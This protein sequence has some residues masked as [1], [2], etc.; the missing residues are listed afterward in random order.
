[1]GVW[2]SL[3]NVEIARRFAEEEPAST[4]WP[5]FGKLFPKASGRKEMNPFGWAKRT[6]A[7]CILI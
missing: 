5:E 3:E 7:R 4:S 6:T 1:M 2:V